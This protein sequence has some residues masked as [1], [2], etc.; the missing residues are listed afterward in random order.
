MMRPPQRGG[1]PYPM[2]PPQGPQSINKIPNQFGPHV[3]PHMQQHPGHH[4]HPQQ[5]MQGHQGQQAQYQG[6]PGMSHK[7]EIIFPP[8]TVEATQ[9]VLYRRKRMTK[10][11]IG[12]NDPWRLFMSLKSGLLAESA[13]ALDVLNVLLFDDSAIAYF[14]LIHLPGLLNLLLEHFQKNLTDM[15]DATN[16]N[17]CITAAITPAAIKYDLDDKDKENI[18]LDGKFKLSTKTT[19]ECGKANGG[20]NN[21]KLSS[22][23]IRNSESGDTRCN[24]HSNEDDNSSVDLGAVTNIPNP[25]ERVVVLKST[26]NYTMQSR[27]GVPVKLQDASN[28]IFITDCQR[29]WDKGSNE[30]Y[31]KEIVGDDPFNVGQDPNSIDYIMKTFKGEI[32]NIPFVRYLKNVEKR[33]SNKVTRKSQDVE[34]LQKAKRIRLTS[35][36]EREIEVMTKNIFKRSIL[37]KESSSDADCRHV[38]MDVEKLSNGPVSVEK[39]EETK[40]E[41]EI[42]KSLGFDLKSTILDPA[43]TLKR[44]RVDDYEDECFSKDEASLC[45]TTDSQDSL[46]RRVLCLSTILRNLTFVP[47]NE[48]EFARSSTFLAILGKLLQ[49]NHEHPIRVKKQRNYDREE[50]ADFSDSCSS[51]QGETEWWSDLLMQIRENM[52]VAI[53]NISGYLDLSVYDEPITRPILDGLLHWAVCPSAQGQDPFPGVTNSLISPQRLAL[54]SLCKLCVTDSNVDLVISTPPFSRLERLCAVLTKHLCKNEDQVL[55][56]FSVNLLHYLASAESSMAR[57]IARQSPCVSYLVAFIEQ[58][59]QTALGVANQH[60]INFLRENPDSMGTSLDMLRRAA[61]TLFHLAKHP[62]N[63]PLFMQ[64]EQRLLGLVMSHILDQ[65]VANIISRVLFQ[66][67]RGSG[68]LTSTQEEEG[69]SEVTHIMPQDAQKGS[70]TQQ[71]SEH[72][73]PPPMSAPNASNLNVQSPHLSQQMKSPSVPQPPTFN[74]TTTK[75]HNTNNE[76][77]MKQSKLK[78]P[79]SSSAPSSA[80]PQTVTASS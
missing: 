30:E 34:Q 29:S 31:L 77:T 57:I 7:R 66:T 36:E 63:R 12:P 55:R 52:L 43:Q 74:S 61:G 71:K 26:Y 1:K 48:L 15:F 32:S 79:T 5:M 67:S 28:D 59:E 17:Y 35:E 3:P 45:H 41:Q 76:D 73:L 37:K 9:P 47:G 18:E 44:L 58:A 64:Q 13:W 56:E 80:I 49:I 6:P 46:V 54:E 14:G 11:D 8:D 16:N 25:L 78:I 20:D 21:T 33:D 4:S 51:L 72:K 19:E 42:E 65:Q 69:Q 53:A 40:N 50:D 60:G 10:H 70:N 75:L 24:E 27:K 2:P 22:N 62:D 38:D 23:L 39:D 68:P